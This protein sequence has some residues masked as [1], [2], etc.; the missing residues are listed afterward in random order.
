MGRVTHQIT[1]TIHG[2]VGNLVYKGKKAGESTVYPYNPEQKK[3]DSAKY[4]DN[5]DSFTTI[6]KFSSAVNDSSLL[7]EIWRTYRN[8]N[9][10][11][12]YNKIHSYNYKHCLPDFVDKYA[13]ILPGGIYCDI[14]DFKHDDDFITV[15]FNP[16]EELLHHIK[17]PFVAI[18]MIYLNSPASKRKGP[19]VLDHNAYLTVETEFDK[20]KFVAGK[21]A[22][23]K[24]RKYK[25]NFS[26]IDDYKRVR[27]WLSLVF[28]SKSG[29]RMWTYSI[30]YLFKGAELDMEYDEM[31]LIKF[32]KRKKEA[33]K[34][35]RAYNEIRFR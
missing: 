28:D 22:K 3:P 13:R 8:I 9:G 19:K 30:S 6:N 11:S 26:V 12:G 24:S 23:I 10:K 34:P 4:K 21:P 2:R 27:V 33:M 5:N 29:K 17:P 15:T 18:V 32:N 35:K 20:H 31:N 7:K 14:V 16:T 25:N 1:G